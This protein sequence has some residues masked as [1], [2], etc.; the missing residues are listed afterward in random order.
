MS[1]KRTPQ[2][3]IDWLKK[4]RFKEHP[5]TTYEHGK[6]TIYIRETKR[7][8]WQF[9]IYEDHMD[10]CLSIWSDTPDTKDE[11]DMDDITELYNL[12]F[13]TDEK[14]L[15][16]LMELAGYKIRSKN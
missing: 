7:K 6:A 8:K 11:E 3:T 4:R 9:D 10:I 5:S 13:A 2:L 16:S 1:T 14:D 12:Q 15:D